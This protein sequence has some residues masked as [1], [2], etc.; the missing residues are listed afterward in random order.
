MV[1]DSQDRPRVVIDTGFGLESVA[2]DAAGVIPNWSGWAN[3]GISLNVGPGQTYLA[4]SGGT[5]YVG[6][7]PRIGSTPPILRAAVYDGATWQ[8]YTLSVTPANL[9][10]L[11]VDAAGQ[12]WWLIHP[13]SV[14]F[15]D[16]EMTI[17]TWG[18]YLVSK[19][20]ADNVTKVPVAMATG[21]GRYEGPS[22]ERPFYQG[23]HALL[24]RFGNLHTIQYYPRG[25]GTLLY[26]KG[27]QAGPLQVFDDLEAGW[28]V[29]LGR[30]SV[31]VDAMGLPHI[32]YTQQWPGYGVKHL[33]WT[34]SAWVSEWIE[35]GGSVSGYLG[36]CPKI[37][38]D[39]VGRLH[40]V[41]GDPMHGLIKHAWKAQGLWQIETIDTVGM[42]TSRQLAAL[43]AAAMDSQ[44]G[45]GVVYWNNDNAE[46]K[47]A[48]R[49]PLDQQFDPASSSEPAV[50]VTNQ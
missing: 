37:L 4:R 21:G 9:F 5:L 8:P 18:Y 26:A 28:A 19:D 33:T 27:P 29:K 50:E 43:P 1:F 44:G 12:P 35:Q 11:V 42:S 38:V 2:G 39:R 22:T 47:Y 3:T 41:Y 48:Y 15:A 31:T 24:D 16:S 13:E 34:G 45:I 49:L 7:R 30:A 10:G 25:G 14:T 46:Y 20:A 23:G 17:P 32:A 36:T 40:V 6:Y